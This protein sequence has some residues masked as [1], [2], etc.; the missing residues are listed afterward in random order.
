VRS[1]RVVEWIIVGKGWRVFDTVAVL[2]FDIAPSL[3]SLFVIDFLVAMDASCAVLV[4]CSRCMDPDTIP[5]VHKNSQDT[6]S[7]G[8]RGFHATLEHVARDM[9]IVDM[10]VF[11]P[12]MRNNTIWYREQMADLEFPRL[13]YGAF[14]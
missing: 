13:P 6:V 7:F 1:R 3:I 9:Y 14:E 5:S 8:N 12:V 2:W 4:C 11:V 10:V